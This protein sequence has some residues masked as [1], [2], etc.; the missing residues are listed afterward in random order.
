MGLKRRLASLVAGREERDGPSPT[1][2][3]AGGST[4]PSDDPDSP[5]DRPKGEPAPS[6]NG[7]STASEP[8]GRVVSPAEGGR[9]D[10][11]SAEPA[12]RPSERAEE[13][14]ESTPGRGTGE[15]PDMGSHE[16]EPSDDSDSG[17]DPTPTAKSASESNEPTGSE[18]EDVADR[19]PD[20]DL[21][22]TSGAPHGRKPEDADGEDVADAVLLGRLDEIEAL[23]ERRIGGVLK[24][25]KD[26]IR[27]DAAKERH[28]DK[29][30][31]EL[32]W[33]R[34]DVFQRASRPLVLG[35][36][37]LHGDVGMLVS[38]WRKKGEDL[39]LDVWLARFE[40]L[41][42]D[43]ELLLDDHGVTAY[44]G[45]VGKPFDGKLQT[46]V[47]NFATAS[48]RKH[49]TVKESRR[50]GFEQEG[51]ILVKERVAVFEFQAPTMSGEPTAPEGAGRTDNK[52]D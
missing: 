18:S 24:E 34:S 41:C 33:Y 2:A 11:S 49:G 17:E 36:I 4:V 44:R 10:D 50:S 14:E 48:E 28:F 40:D 6:G 5:E 45:D 12:P 1:R 38:A 16:T 29:L 31:Q 13:S 9:D 30:H 23:L 26:K 47:E 21:A 25:F 7:G 27:Y 46:I 39:P 3:E 15:R 51:R 35:M 37:A 52:E 32:E 19:E 20:A 22:P 42:T 43:I 8:D